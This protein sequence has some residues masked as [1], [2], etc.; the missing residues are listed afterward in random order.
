MTP[1]EAINCLREWY[2][3]DKTG[4]IDSGACV[5]AFEALEKQIPKAINEVHVDEYYCPAC[6]VENNCYQGIVEDKFCPNCGQ[7]L[8]WSERDV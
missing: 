8:D 2:K 3:R 7:A 4:D 6:G 5:V 1:Q